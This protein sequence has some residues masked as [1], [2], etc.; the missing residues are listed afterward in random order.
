MQTII[1]LVLIYICYVINKLAKNIYVGICVITGCNGK[2]RFETE[3]KATSNSYTSY[4]V[5][6]KHSQH[7]TQISS[8]NNIQERESLWNHIV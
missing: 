3:W 4:L 2:L 8:S 1:L 6:T 7:K 5:C